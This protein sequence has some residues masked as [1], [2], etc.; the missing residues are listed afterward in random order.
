MLS[1]YKSLANQFNDVEVY[2]DV[3]SKF[4]ITTPFSHAFQN[5]TKCYCGL[6]AVWMIG[7]SRYTNVFDESK[8][9]RIR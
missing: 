7:P 8:I 2:I 4:I 9:N 6:K 5:Y 1:R 3:N